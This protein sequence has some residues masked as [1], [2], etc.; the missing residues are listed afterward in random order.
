MKLLRRHRLDGF[1]IALAIA[2][3]VALVLS[4]NDGS[5]LAAGLAGSAS[6]ALLARRRQPLL[7][8]VVAFALLAGS[9]AAAPKSPNVQFFELMAT[10]AVVA[11]INVTRD[12]VIAWSAGA[13]FIGVGTFT[14]DTDHPAGDFLLTLAFCTVMWVAGWLVSRHTRRADVM[15]LRARAAEQERAIAVRDERAR[16]AREL[17]DVVSHGLSVVVLQT[18]AARTAISDG[19]GGELERHLDAVESTSRDALGEMRRMLG[20][21][22]VD[23]LD[24]PS[25]PAPSAGIRNL[26][27]L[28]DRARSAGLR[29]DDTELDSDASLPA[30]VEL[31][32]YRVVQEALTNAA[33]HAPGAHVRVA[34]RVDAK[35]VTVDITDDGGTR[36]G[37]GLGG[38][39]HGLIGMRERVAIY[40]G[41]L[42]AAPIPAGGF[43]VRATLPLESTGVASTA[44]GR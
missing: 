39:G 19:D 43:T 11:A 36:N 5:Y 7:A 24:E 32:L 3:V 10:F 21:L 9:L 44:A 6:L 12:G 38:A 30:G 40:R 34:L 29:V 28:I 27:A 8:S 17:H 41:T 16:I 42:H 23:D 15:A 20:L 25:Q 13:A 37:A 4:D 18:L 2:A 14:A 22:Q 26:P 1:L 33:K 35:Q 31:A